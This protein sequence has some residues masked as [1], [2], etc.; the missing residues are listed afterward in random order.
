MTDLY[1]RYTLE[2]SLRN[3]GEFEKHFD[4]S[5]RMFKSS[6]NLSDL[7]IFTDLNPQTRRCRTSFRHTHTHLYLH[8]SV[9]FFFF[10]VL[11]TVLPHEASV[12]AVLNLRSQE[13]FYL[14]L[15]FMGNMK[16]RSD[17]IWCMVACLYM[18]LSG[19]FKQ[20]NSSLCSGDGGRSQPS[21]L[22][23]LWWWHVDLHVHLCMSAWAVLGTSLPKFHPF[24]LRQSH[25]SM[26]YMI[27]WYRYGH[28]IK[29]YIFFSK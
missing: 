2:K 12:I 13:P 26:K 28:R 9:Y 1:G 16:H 27:T 11:Y 19:T 18:P 6:S 22:S 15:C 10:A 4:K 21:G 20:L 23:L 29:L 7:G 3:L 5:D 24:L 8:V 17:R 14:T 25:K